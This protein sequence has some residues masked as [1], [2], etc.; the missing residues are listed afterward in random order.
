M[1]LI[2]YM[3]SSRQ[4]LQKCIHVSP[5]DVVAGPTDLDDTGTY[6]KHTLHRK[7]RLLQRY[8]YSRPFRYTKQE[9]RSHLFGITIHTCIRDLSGRS[10]NREA[11]YPD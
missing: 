5:W 4:P 7:E 9:E 10:F 2:K 8:K 3:Q 1:P 6:I 11:F